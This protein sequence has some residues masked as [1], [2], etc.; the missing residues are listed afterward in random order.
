LITFGCGNTGMLLATMFDENAVLFST[1]LQDTTNFRRRN[2]KI[3]VFSDVGASKRFKM[4]INIWEANIEKLNNIL[5]PI[6]SEKVIIFSSLGGGSGSSSLVPFSRILIE[7]NNK[8][9]ILAPLPFK[10]EQ[11]PPLSNAV[12]AINSLMPI[13]GSVSV[14]LFDNEKLR[15]MFDND[16]ELINGYIIHRADYIINLLS[17]HIDEEGYSPLTLDQ[18]ELE[19]VIFGGGFIDY[20]DTFLEESMPKFEYGAIDKT[21]KNCLIAMYVDSSASARSLRNYHK[22]FTEIMAHVAGR[23][24]NARI[25]PGILRATVNN[26]NALDKKIKDRAYVTI[27]SGLNV[28]RYLKKISK[29]REKAVVKATIYAKIYKGKRVIKKKREERVLDL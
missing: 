10:R 18:S 1:A 3:N 20:S 5:S 14:M 11:N 17:R 27:A 12:Q 22:T 2:R 13:I 6:K 8:V 4:G 25:I 29:I 9:L 28:D 24:S 15:K 21:T 16:W 26:S 23:A 7:N 19:S